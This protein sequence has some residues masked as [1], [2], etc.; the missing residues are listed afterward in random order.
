MRHK[1]DT[2]GIV[3]ARTAVGEAN[4][5]IA[6]LTQE[7]GLVRARAQGV[8]KSGAK[9]AH[10]LTTFTESEVVLVQGKEYWRIAGAVLKENWFLRMSRAE[11]RTRAARVANLLLRLVAG[12]TRDS[13]LFEII[14][15]FFESLVTLSEEKHEQAE[16]LTVLGI[17]AALGLDT[18]E[19]PE[20]IKEGN[21]TSYIRRIN[22]GIEASGL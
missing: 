5:S 22:R 14:R 1:Y 4:D 15:N 12:E 2:C 18:G 11:T 7:V 3:L 9:L 13:A 16:I 21:Y 17:L 10:A 20:E 19:I 8:R 6:I